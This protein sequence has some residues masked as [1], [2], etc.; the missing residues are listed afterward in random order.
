MIRA[1]WEL[2]P[3]SFRGISYRKCADLAEGLAT[4]A[5]PLVASG[6]APSRGDTTKLTAVGMIFAPA[7]RSVRITSRGG[8]VSTVTARRSSSQQSRTAEL[9]R[10]KYAAFS[11][12]GP[13]CAAS[14]TT[15]GSSGRVLW[16][17]EVD[18]TC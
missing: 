16:D 8:E 10:F 1:K 17:G 7:V 6:T 9:G 11:V 18:A 4:T 5:P 15:L 14:M 12:R 3:F 13:W 2:G